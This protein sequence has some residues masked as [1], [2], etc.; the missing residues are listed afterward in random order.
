MAWETVSKY[1][2]KN[3][4]YRV[5][6]SYT[7]GSPVYTAWAAG[8]DCIDCFPTV[9]EAKAACIGHAAMTALCNFVCRMNSHPTTASA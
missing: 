6:L 2:L 9:D 8:S 5:S 3:G 1:S 4:S 7:N